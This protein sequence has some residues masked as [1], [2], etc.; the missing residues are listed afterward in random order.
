MMTYLENVH[1]LSVQVTEM[2]SISLLQS[3]EGSAAGADCTTSSMAS[4]RLPITSLG[5][6]MRE[7]TAKTTS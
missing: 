4:Q 5:L 7:Q 3:E 6:R 1:I 2:A